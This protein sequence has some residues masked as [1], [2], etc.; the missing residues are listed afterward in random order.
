MAEFGL[1]SVRLIL[2]ETVNVSFSMFVT[3]LFRIVYVIQ[4]PQATNRA[5]GVQDMFLWFWIN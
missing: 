3:F 4:T 2:A 5:H 1:E